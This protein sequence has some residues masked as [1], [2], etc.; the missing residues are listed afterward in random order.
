MAPGVGKV[1]AVATLA[2]QAGLDGGGLDGADHVAGLL[3]RLP[4]LAN[5]D[6]VL[7]TSTDIAGLRRRV[8]H[9]ATTRAVPPPRFANA[10][11]ASF[12]QRPGVEHSPALEV[13]E[14]PGGT[15][16]RIGR[17]P[18]AL[19]DP[20][21]VLADVSSP[22]AG[23]VH[24]YDFDLARLVADAVPVAGAALVL[25]CDLHPVNYCHWLVDE[26]PR[27]AALGGAREVTLI[28]S[29][30]DAPFRDETWRL[31]A[32][33][34]AR[35]V[36]LGDFQAVRAER[37]LVTADL[38][39]MPHP[40]FKAAPWALDFLRARV[41]FPALAGHAPSGSP[42]KL[43]VSRDDAVGRRVLN[44]AA[45]MQ[46]LEPAG[47][48]RMTLAG[49]SVAE[50]VA[51]FSGATHVVGA[52]GAGLANIVFCPPEARLLELFPSSYGTPTYYVLAAG[53][54]LTYA[55]YVVSDIACGD[56]AQTDDIR[57]DI[58]DFRRCCAGLI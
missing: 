50:Q 5:R 26:L 55:T 10:R 37:L 31:C 41:G 49:R 27:I 35:V 28:V 51:L 23:L 53:Q 54:G 22:Y 40:A 12:P 52:H 17:A 9:P 42:R 46:V 25:C 33:P 2:R 15:L 3:A 1:E 38:A 48:Q 36:R 7:R 29:D 32:I 16:A 8:I 39:A 47:Y 57:V 34:T 13:L 4:R 20:R 6:V 21:T 30:D 14:L 44:E 56:R 18:V 19:A 24:G 45:L 58:N 11:P 43:F